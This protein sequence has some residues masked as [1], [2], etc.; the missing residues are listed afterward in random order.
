MS[1]F[2]VTVKGRKKENI[3]P[4]S[5]LA[6]KGDEVHFCVLRYSDGSAVQKEPE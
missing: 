5:H 4:R 6:L 2:S 3:D 1:L